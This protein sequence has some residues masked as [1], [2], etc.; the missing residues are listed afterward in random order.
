MSGNTPRPKLCIAG[1]I[2]HIARKKNLDK[3]STPTTFEM[4]WASPEDFSDLKGKS[5]F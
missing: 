3:K 1:K 2:L 4:R 5:Y